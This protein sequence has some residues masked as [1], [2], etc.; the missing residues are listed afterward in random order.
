MVTQEIL[1]ELLDYDPEMKITG[2]KNEEMPRL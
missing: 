1:R 2:V